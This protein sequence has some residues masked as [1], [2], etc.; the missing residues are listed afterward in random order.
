MI[1]PIL[2]NKNVYIDLVKKKVFENTDLGW[3][4]G[5]KTHGFYIYVKELHL[6]KSTENSWILSRK[7]N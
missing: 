6:F 1:D 3:T 5:W 4:N 7:P 2:L